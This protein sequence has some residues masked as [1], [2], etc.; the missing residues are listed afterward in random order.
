MK[1]LIIEDE[2]RAQRS[3][4]KLLDTHFPQVR[5]IG[6]TGS[7]KDTVAWL[8]VHD[9]VAAE[10]PDVIFMDVELSDGNCFD[11]F[12]QIQVKAPVVMTTAYDNYAVKAFEVNSLDYL[13]KPL[14]VADM[15]RALDRVAARTGTAPQ[16]DMVRVME[17]FQALQTGSEEYAP[18]PVEPTSRKE[19]FLIRLNDRIVPVHTRSVAYFYSESKNSYIVTD[20]NTTYVLDDSLDTIEQSLPADAFFRISRSCIIAESAIDSVSRLLGGRLRISLRRGLDAFTDLTVS[21]ARVDAF[22]TWLER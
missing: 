20:K 1:A 4:Q 7:V 2:P 19:K 22:L 18:A 16:V 11:I 10:A 9:G 12:K 6:V 5:T 8:K 21:R 3:M 14:E 15:R 13:L 17:A